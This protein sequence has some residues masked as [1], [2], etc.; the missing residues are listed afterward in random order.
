V[1]ETLRKLATLHNKYLNNRS[2]LITLLH[3]TT[4][5]VVLFLQDAHKKGKRCR[6]CNPG[7]VNRTRLIATSTQTSNQRPTN[8]NQ[9]LEIFFSQ[10]PMFQYQPENSPVMEFKRLC[11][12]CGW[13]KESNEKKA[14][15][16][17]FNLAMAKEFNSLFGSDEKDINNWYKLCHVLR[18]EP[19]PDTLK[20][21]RAVSTT[22][23]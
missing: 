11:E 14:A 2:R 7:C 21:C 6:V 10:Y 16:R 19:V 18:I 13:E 17:K 9:P 20:E 5:L 1:R 22:L 12:E 8:Q 4:T 23:L 15:R 3:T